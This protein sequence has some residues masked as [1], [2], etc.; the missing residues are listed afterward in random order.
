MANAKLAEGV[1]ICEIENI[2]NHLD[3]WPFDA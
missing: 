3:H 1:T 2:K